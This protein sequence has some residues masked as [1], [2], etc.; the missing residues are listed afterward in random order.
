L[1]GRHPAAVRPAD[2]LAVSELQ[3][4]V[5]GRVEALRDR[6]VLT[7]LALDQS[8]DLGGD[9][10]RAL[11]IARDT[12]LRAVDLSAHERMHATYFVMAPLY[13]LGRWREI[14]PL[15][16]EHLAAFAEETVDMNCPFTRGGPV[17][18]AI[19]L[20]QMGRL[21]AAAE[22][23]GSIVPNDKE[24]GTVEARMA[25]RALLAGG[26]ATAREIAL[27]TIEFGRDLTVEQP[28]YELPVLV[29][30]LAAL[31]R[32]DELEVTSSAFRDRAANVAWL[33]PALDRAEAWR[34][35]ERGDSAGA[36]S[37]LRRALDAYRRLGM[38]PE[39]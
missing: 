20:D 2:D 29:D 26:P 37:G 4:V 19:V 28:P 9:F 34:L 23:S 33:A 38:L 16:D 39:V 15:L 14:L 36:K 25:E 13:R 1:S 5:V 22:A 24:P 17:I 7:S 3:L 11:E 31:G 27:R 35:A 8:M 6:L 12:R 10:E 30:A 32:W 21:D 18:G